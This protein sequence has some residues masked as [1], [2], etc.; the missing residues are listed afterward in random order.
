MMLNRYRTE[1]TDDKTM[2]EVSMKLFTQQLAF[3]LPAETAIH[4]IKY[5]AAWSSDLV[6]YVSSHT[7]LA[8]RYGALVL[9]RLV[10]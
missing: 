2:N 6:P 8:R 10:G 4:V 9:A 3:N 5:G 1:K 7:E